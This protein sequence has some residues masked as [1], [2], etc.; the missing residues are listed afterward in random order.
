MKEMRDYCI[1]CDTEVTYELRNEL[2][3][4][5]IKGYD[6]E[7]T[8]EVP[9]CTECGE[10]MHINK[11]SD[12]IIQQANEI[13]REEVGIIKVSEIQELLD[14]YNIGKKPLAKLLGWGEATIIRYLEGETPSIEYSNRLKQLINVMN[15]K[16]LYKKGKDKLTPVAQRKI[17]ASF[18]RLLSFEKPKEGNTNITAFEVA[19]Y[20]LTKAD[21]AITH[22]ALQK[23]VYFTQSWSSVFLPKPIFHEE[24]QAWVHGPVVP[25][26]YH[27]Y[28]D[29]GFHPLPQVKDFDTTIFNDT[30]IALLEMIWDVYSKY[31]AKALEELTHTEDPWKKH[32][33]YIDADEKSTSTISIDDMFNYYYPLK[34][35]LQINLDSYEKLDQYVSHTI[36]QLLS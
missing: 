18:D 3:K 8:A 1:Y 34:D 13:Y 23:L 17:E 6:I 7:F 25:R 20:F 33:K 30:Q 5:N 4:M 27:I 12:K 28:K 36:S 2:I 24:I 19:Q 26:L 11:Y 16:E 35:E 21:E 10:Q 29:Y 9:Y 14:K 32:R 31:H 15:M 22:L